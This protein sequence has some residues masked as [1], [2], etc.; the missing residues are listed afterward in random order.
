MLLGDFL[1]PQLYDALRRRRF[2]TSGSA[3]QI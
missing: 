2:T 1:V 3:T